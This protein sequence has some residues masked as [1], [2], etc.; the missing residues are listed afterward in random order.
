MPIT[1]KFGTEEYTVGPHLHAKFGPDR[2]RGVGTVAPNVK[3]R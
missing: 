3:I 1:M 2:G